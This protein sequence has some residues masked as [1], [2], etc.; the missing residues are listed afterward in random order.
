[1]A[2]DDGDGRAPVALAADAPVA[3]SPGGLLLADALGGQQFGHLV[4]RIL[5]AQAVEHAG[6]D[7]H[8]LDLVAVAV[9][10][11]GG[12]E[13]LAVHGHHLLDGDAVLLGE[14][15]V[16]LV[17]RGHAHHGAVAIGHQHVVADPHLDLRASERV[18]DEQ[19]RGHALLLLRGQ[20]GLGGAAL[21]ALVDEG[22]KF[23]FDAG[24]VRGQR[25]FVRGPRRRRSRP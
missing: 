5:V 12:V 10:P 6:V 16:A 24:G 13:G 11:G 23:G 21:L 19:A 1:V 25:G 17:V 7:A 3:Q 22:L 18:R 4:D 20:F 8:A 9:L 15:E 2:V 14:G